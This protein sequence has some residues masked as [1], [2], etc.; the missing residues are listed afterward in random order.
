MHELSLAEDMRDLILERASQE[1]FGAVEKVWLEIGELS[2]VEADAMAFCFDSVMAGTLVEGAQ[3]E[4]ISVP[5]EGECPR[6]GHRCQVQALYDAC[7]E[8]GSF[9]LGIVQG[10]DVRVKSLSVI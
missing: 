7:P 3:L 1:R 8:C 2:C 5:G 9:G 6:C 4:I 10:R